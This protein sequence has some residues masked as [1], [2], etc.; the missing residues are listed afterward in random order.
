MILTLQHTHGR[1]DNYWTT[2]ELL[3]CEVNTKEEAFAEMRRFLDVNGIRSD[4]TSVGLKE[5]HI[6]IGR[7][8]PRHTEVNMWCDSYID[9]YD[10]GCKITGVIFGLWDDKDR[11]RYEKLDD[12]KGKP[13]KWFD[14][15]ERYLD[16]LIARKAGDRQCH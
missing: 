16:D 15:A 12:F 3:L 14:C 10:E 5:E 13:E 9:P 1:Y 7:L 11:P 6:R 4:C 2:I 8:I